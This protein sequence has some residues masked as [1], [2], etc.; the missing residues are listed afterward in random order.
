L[1]HSNTEQIEINLAFG[2][3]AYSCELVPTIDDSL[4]FAQE[5]C[6]WHGSG[7]PTPYVV[8]LGSGHK[9][10]R[11][12]QEAEKFKGKIASHVL[13]SI[14]GWIVYHFH[15]TSDSSQLKKTN[16][17]ND[18]IYLRND[19]GNLAAFLYRL[20]NDSLPHYNL[21]RAHI[22]M[23]APFF[24]DFILRPL[25][26][27]EEKIRL[28]WMEKGSDYPFPGYHLSDGTLRFICLATLRS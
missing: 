2:R 11:L 8:D 27:N 16:N 14:K 1:G 9:E 10:S 21:I 24:D 20:K 23:V 3:N 17:I 28:E 6:Y 5:T 18:N 12:P 19:A 13:E 7:F 22:R 25:P 4:V 15:D 26:E